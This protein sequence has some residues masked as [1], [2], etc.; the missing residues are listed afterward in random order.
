M[1]LGLGALYVVFRR[2]GE[3]RRTMVRFAIAFP[4]VLAVV[5]AVSAGS[6]TWEQR[7]PGHPQDLCSYNDSVP[8]MSFIAGVYALAALGR[9]W[10]L[11]VER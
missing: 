5:G 10:M 2:F 4:I 1:S 8:A 11:F 6:E 7:C 3:G 9:A